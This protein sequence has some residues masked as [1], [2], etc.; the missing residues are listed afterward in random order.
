MK[1][2]SNRRKNEKREYL[3]NR[4]SYLTQLL[5]FCVQRMERKK[6]FSGKC[7]TKKYNILSSSDVTKVILKL[8]DLRI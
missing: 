8:E 6:T 1:K 3:N 2:N 5:N 4:W 7:I